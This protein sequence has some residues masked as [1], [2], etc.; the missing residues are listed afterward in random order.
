MS[1][2]DIECDDIFY[3]VDWGD[4][5]LSTWDGPFNSSQQVQMGHWW[6]TSGSYEV[7][8]KAKD[9]YGAESNWSEPYGVVITEICIEIGNI[10]G[11]FGMVHVV[12]Q[13]IGDAEAQ[14]VSYSIRILGKRIWRGRETRG[15]IQSISLG[16]EVSVSSDPIL[17]FGKAMIRVEASLPHEI[18]TKTVESVVMLVY[19][20]VG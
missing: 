15:I 1:S 20:L 4:G 2:I 5:T 7:R 3:L 12:F 6:E 11:G 14:D 17:G 16:G 10:T 8:V 13:N 19:I 9:E 18:Y